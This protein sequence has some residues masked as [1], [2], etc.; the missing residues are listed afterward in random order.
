M[1]S[2]NN[3]IMVFWNTIPSDFPYLAVLLQIS[4]SFNKTC[5]FPLPGCAVLVVNL[6]TITI[7]TSQHCFTFSC[8]SCASECFMKGVAKSLRGWNVPKATIGSTGSQ[9]ITSFS[10]LGGGLW[11]LDRLGL[12]AT[13]CFPACFG[14]EG[15]VHNPRVGSHRDIW[16]DRPAGTH[17]KLQPFSGRKSCWVLCI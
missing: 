17:L 14:K 9:L 5:T 12:P 1:H 11:K 3:Q 6:D 2:V 10:P 16:C 8:Q 13:L 4:S 7:V 15:Q